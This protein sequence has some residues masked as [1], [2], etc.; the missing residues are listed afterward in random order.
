ME[1]KE[2]RDEIEID[3][4]EIVFVLLSRIWYILLAGITVGLMA[5]IV[6]KFVI[7]PQYSSTTK[8]YVLSKEKNNSSL[9]V[10]DLQMGSQL[11]KDYVE[12]V[13]SRTVLTQVISEL[14]LDLS[15]GA[16]SGMISVDTP[17]DSRIIN[18]TVTHP[19]A[20]LA[21]DIANEV[22]IVAADHICNVMDLEAVNLVDEANIPTSPSSPNVFRNT[23]IGALLGII[24][25]MAIIVISHLSDDTIKTPDEVE[26]YMGVSVLGSIPVLESEEKGKKKK[27]RNKSKIRQAWGVRNENSKD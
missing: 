13:K 4:R 6:S 17:S 18:I 25:A 11:T 10:S 1:Q 24:L 27:K 23:L 20:Y 12:L 15:T 7:T 16:L 2:T 19:D 9:T 21:K 26:R 14:N 5:L 22:R 8:I 3:I